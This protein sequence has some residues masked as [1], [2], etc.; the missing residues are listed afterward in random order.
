MGW[1]ELRESC[2]RGAGEGACQT[3]GA[4]PE[5]AACWLPDLGRDTAS[6][7][8][9]VSSSVGKTEMVVVTGQLSHLPLYH[10]VFSVSRITG[11]VFRPRCGTLRKIRDL[12]GCSIRPCFAQIFA[13][14]DG[15]LGVM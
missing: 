10:P 7:Q 8:A 12:S 3:P 9:P 2:V 1:T 13:Q 6:R 5:A 15:A 11:K 14:T 4:N